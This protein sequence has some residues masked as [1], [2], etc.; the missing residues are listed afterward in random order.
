MFTGVWPKA[1][2]VSQVELAEAS[3]AAIDRA[4]GGYQVNSLP[5]SAAKTALQARLAGIVTI[6]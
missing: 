2:V 1:H 3:R 5:A 4:E 6:S